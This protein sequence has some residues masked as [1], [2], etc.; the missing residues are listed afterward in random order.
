LGAI[1]G[2]RDAVAGSASSLAGIVRRVPWARNASTWILVAGLLAAYAPIGLAPLLDPASWDYHDFRLYYEAASAFA[3]GDPPYEIALPLG[4]FTLRY[5]YPPVTLLFFVPF[6]WLSF[7]EACIAYLAVKAAALVVL[8]IVWFRVFVHG[9][10][11]WF[12][13]FC[14]LAFNSALYIDVEVGNTEGFIELLIWTGLAAFVSGR[15]RAF[16]IFILSAALFKL[17]PAALLLLLGLT[18][19]PGKA[20]RQAV[21]PII[22]FIVILL[23]SAFLEPGWLTRLIDEAGRNVALSAPV[24]QSVLSLLRTLL[25]AGPWALTLYLV[26]AIAIVGLTTLIAARVRSVANSG[27]AQFAAVYLVVLAYMLVSPRLQDYQMAMAIVPCFYLIFNTRLPAA[28]LLFLFVVVQAVNIRLPGMI[29]F[30]RT[31][32]NYKLLLIVYAAWILLALELWRGPVHR[33]AGQA[34]GGQPAL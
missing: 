4:S 2:K 13:L 14:L 10:R 25:G 21:L 26:H 23:A 34:D 11:P 8:I 9:A 22:T 24:N 20:L 33:G 19:A 12:L 16:A 17:A 6:T 30:Y 27:H 1:V 18:A 29:E 7:D 28:P 3:R 15:Y 5:L 31:F 32:F